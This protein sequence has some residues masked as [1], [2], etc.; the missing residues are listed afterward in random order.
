MKTK[1][2]RKA[3]LLDE[4]VRDLKGV[5]SHLLSIDDAEIIRKH[6]EIES[7][8]PLSQDPYA[9]EIFKGY[10]GCRLITAAVHCL[11]IERKHLRLSDM[12]HIQ[13]FRDMRNIGKK[14]LWVYE[15]TMREFGFTDKL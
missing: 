11:G 6:D 2:Q 8:K 10:C 3:E 9:D 1:E 4:I 14:S 13:V 7:S 12:P 15:E 5:H